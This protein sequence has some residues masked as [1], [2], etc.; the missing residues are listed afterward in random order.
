MIVSEFVP[1]KC[2]LFLYKYTSFAHTGK[3]RRVVVARSVAP[4][5]RQR[6]YGRLAVAAF[7]GTEPRRYHQT[8]LRM[9]KVI[10]AKLV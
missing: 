1:Q 10:T 9:D 3:S 4:L 5:W 7:G 6:R 8:P 2:K